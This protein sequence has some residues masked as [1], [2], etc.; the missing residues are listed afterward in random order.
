M[1]QQANLKP[2]IQIVLNQFLTETMK[3][4]RILSVSFET[5][6]NPWELNRFRGAVAQK[7]GYE[8]EWFHNHNNDTGGYHQRYPL[9]Q[10]KLD[11]KNGLMRPMLLCIEEGVEEAQHFFSKDDWNLRIG[12]HDHEMRIANLDVR[13]HT[14]NVWEQDF[15]YRIH[16]WQA[17]NTDNFATWKNLDGIA[18]RFHFLEQTLAA[19]ILSFAR[20]VGWEL[21]RHFDLRITNQIKEEWISYKGVKVLAFSLEFKTNA[22]LPDYIGLGKGSSVG[23]GIVRRQ[24]NQNH[25]EFPEQ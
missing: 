12:E 24:K 13:Q 9:I 15:R 17:L 22:S 10:Y 5:K 14:L 7:V 23:W 8:H 18:A 20:G 2:Q 11:S 1:T 19:H 25:I 16:K 21:D 6:V 4:L 3:K